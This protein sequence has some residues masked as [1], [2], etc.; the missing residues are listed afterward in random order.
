[1]GRTWYIDLGSQ[2][3][4]MYGWN[5]LSWFFFNQCL[6]LPSVFGGIL[7]PKEAKM[8]S[9]SLASR[10]QGVTQAL[11]PDSGQG[12]NNAKREELPRTQ[13][14]EVGAWGKASVASRISS[15][16]GALW[17]IRSTHYVPWTQERLQ[18]CLPGIASAGFLTIFHNVG[19][20]LAWFQRFCELFSA[21]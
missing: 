1:M 20:L 6:N 9:A 4:E 8:L 18:W 21:L 10:A 2:S 5:H 17:G 7:A 16:N 19:Q 3:C 11:V 13:H 14:G 12:I 15:G